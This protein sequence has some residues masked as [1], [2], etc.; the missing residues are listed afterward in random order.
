MIWIVCVNA[1]NYEGQGKRYVEI[2][3]DMVIRHFPEGVLHKF[4]C[5]T[6]DPEPYHDDIQKRPL[7]GG[8]KGWWNKLYLFKKGHFKD[9][10]RII[11][12]D[13]DTCIVGDL[14]EIV[15]YN[16]SFAI[17]SDVYRKGGLQSSVMMWEAGNEELENIWNSY[18]SSGF[19]N[20]EGGD[21]AWIES[22]NI[23]SD[24]IQQKY[25]DDFASYFLQSQF[26]I[27]R[28]AKVVFFHGHP[29]PHQV[30][31]NWVPHIWK[32]GGHLV[33]T[34]KTVGNVDDSILQQNVDYA[35][36]LP[37]EILADQYMTPTHT[38]LVICGGG[39]SLAD[40]LEKILLMQRNGAVIWALNNTFRYLSEHGINPDA[41]I[42][43]DAREEN[44]KF[45]PE[46]TEAMLLYSAQCHPKLLDKA[47]KAAERVVIWVPA[48]KDIMKILSKHKKLA[49]I[50]SGGSS[51]GMKA[52]GLAYGLGFKKVHLFGYDSS[53]RKEKNHAYSQPLN[54]A[55][56]IID[57]TVNDQ[58][59]RCAPWMATQVEEFKYSIPNFLARGMEFSVHGDGLLPYV[60]S[61][62]EAI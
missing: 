30:K 57:I 36:S 9:G 18:E 1:H 24:I 21:Q 62:M 58:H 23:S 39:P 17:L 27:P 31:G 34:W 59:Y 35:L 60:A 3:Y 20:I 53:Y 2:L 22:Q 42:M 46:K 11:Y 61:L 16:G 13:L 43:L 52:L 37:C 33:R 38:P 54:D 26:D 14:D 4:V 47:I 12:F 51:V 5:F 56:R 49:L 55:E 44:I 15:Q 50:V 19:P 41:H 40:N 6:D 29:R 7:H 10:D 28:Y 25:P 32:I 45:L 48:I 8:L